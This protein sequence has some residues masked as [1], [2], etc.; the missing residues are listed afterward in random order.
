[1]CIFKDFQKRGEAYMKGKKINN[2][3]FTLL[4][5]VICFALLGI[6]MVAAAQVISSSTQVYYYTKSVTYGLQTSQ[7]VATEVKGDLCEAMPVLLKN[8]AT[9]SDKVSSTF[10]NQLFDGGAYSIFISD[11]GR[12][13]AFIKSTGEQIMYWME[14]DDYGSSTTDSPDILVRSS[15]QVYDQGDYITPLYREQAKKS[16]TTQYVGMNYKVKDIK[17]SLYTKAT[18]ESFSSIE[19]ATPLPGNNM[20]SEYPII[21]LEITVNNSRYGDYTCTEY[22]PLYNFYGI[23]NENIYNLIHY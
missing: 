7:V 12:S 3:G 15:Q 6:L 4:E 2:D 22:I 9:D 10:E 14:N 20:D 18:L 8:D 1:M 13:I 11:D 17:F 19:A 16:F 5:M 23:S 21:Q